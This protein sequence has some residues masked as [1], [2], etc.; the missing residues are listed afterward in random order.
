MQ[1][2]PG[3]EIYAEP[4]LERNRAEE[5]PLSISNDSRRITHTSLPDLMHT[6]CPASASKGNG[7]FYQGASNTSL[8]S[9]QEQHWVRVK[10]HACSRRQQG[11]SWQKP[12]VVLTLQQCH[13]LVSHPRLKPASCRADNSLATLQSVPVHR[14]TVGNT[15]VSQSSGGKVK[16]LNLVKHREHQ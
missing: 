1:Q 5:K 6:E 15:S 7:G 13:P 16:A 2:V 11:G 8:S 10:A 9:K 3:K 4:V 12:G 14:T